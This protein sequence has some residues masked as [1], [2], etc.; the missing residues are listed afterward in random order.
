MKKNLFLLLVVVST[1]CSLFFSG[2]NSNSSDGMTNEANQPEQ[3]TPPAGE[4][5]Q[6]DDVDIETGV[7]ASF[8]HGYGD[9][10]FLPNFNQ[11]TPK[12]VEIQEG[13]SIENTDNIEDHFAFKFDTYIYI[14]QSGDYTFYILSNNHSLLKI[15]DVTFIDN[16]TQAPDQYWNHE[17]SG[18]VHLTKGFHKLELQFHEI[19]NSQKLIVEYEGPSINK[20]SIPT[21]LLFLQDYGPDFEL[22]PAPSLEPDYYVN[23]E[24]NTTGSVVGTRTRRTEEGGAK[25]EVSENPDNE[26]SLNN[27]ELSMRVSTVPSRPDNG[28]YDGH[29]RAELY[30]DWGTPFPTENKKHVYQWNVFFPEGFLDQITIDGDWHLITQ[31]AT[32][33]CARGMSGFENAI[34]YSGGIF[35]EVRIDRNDYGK[36]GFQFRA[37]PDCN[38]I[39]YS[40]PEDKWI[41]LTLEIYWDNDDEDSESIADGFYRVWADENLIGEA[42]GVVTLPRG[43]TNDSQCGIRWKVGLYDKWT[44]TN[45]SVAEIHYFVDNLELYIGNK[46]DQMIESICPGCLK[47]D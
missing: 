18:S 7:I 9:S 14:E 27:S 45:S 29:T 11:L 12:K 44:T 28:T 37:Q 36:Y 25:I 23:F 20:Q 15:D 33:P 24:D 43:Y 46:D 31:F 3:D 26:N 47:Q 34:C 4:E 6:Q 40:Y 22:D 16:N 2:C 8:Y 19:D 42:Y 21:E 5:E 10:E 30:N 17:A 35:N 39:S 38:T 32:H 41:K 1:T 13:F